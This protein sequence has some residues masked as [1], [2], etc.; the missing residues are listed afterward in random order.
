MKRSPTPAVLLLLALFATTTTVA[1]NQPIPP[2]TVDDLAWFEGRWVGQLGES[3]IEEHWSGVDG[4]TIIG[5]F[6]VVSAGKSTPNR[7]GLYEFWAVEP[8]DH[9]PELRMRHFSPGLTAWEEKDAPLVFRV[10]ATGERMVAFEVEEE[11]G[12]VRLTYT[13]PEEDRLVA[14][15]LEEGETRRFEYRRM[16]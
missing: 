7:V 1:A 14:E 10:V 11:N 13:R 5:M 16:E 12:P 6:R 8:G 15:L 3:I 9:G 4:G 2:P